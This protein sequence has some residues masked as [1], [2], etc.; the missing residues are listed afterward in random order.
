M[1]DARQMPPTYQAEGRQ[2]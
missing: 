2:Y 1:T